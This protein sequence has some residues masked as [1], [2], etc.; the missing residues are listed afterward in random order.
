[1]PSGAALTP[2][3]TVHQVAERAGVSIAT[4]SRVL[5]GKGGS[6]TTEERVRDAV[7]A[8]GYRPD[9]AGRALKLG[10][11]LQVAFAVDDLA[12]PVYTD[13][14]GGVE[15]GLADSGSRLL[16]ASTGHAVEDLLSL[17]AS[18]DRGYADGLV[19][20]PLVR[21]PVLLAALEA[22]SVPV[23]LVG[24]MPD[25]VRLDSVRT[26]SAAGVALALD[27]LVATGRRHVV[28]VNGP[29]ST[30]PAQMRAAGF[31]QATRRVGIA[32]DTVTADS[33]TADGG[34]QAWARLLSEG[35]AVEFDAVLAA[36]DLLAIGVMRAARASGRRVP[37]DLAV[38]GIDD[39]PFAPLFSPSLTTVSLGARERG[40]LAAE[41][42]LGRLADPGLPPRTVRIAPELIVRESTQRHEEL[43]TGGS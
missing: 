19:I 38:T 10:R 17:V 32:S 1:M 13:M 14:M 7:R 20:S 26:D 12:N 36:N 35:R 42:L 37:D 23:V 4:V 3:P 11:T 40:R 22:A 8:L 28:F 34:E 31:A 39:I 2:R 33:F 6:R 29:G 27:H 16:V 30:V 18:L 9:A 15:A 21:P 24:N 43:L 41:L 5:N 25:H